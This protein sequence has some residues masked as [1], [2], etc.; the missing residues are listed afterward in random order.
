MLPSQPFAVYEPGTRKGNGSATLAE[1]IHRL[2]VQALGVLVI[3]QQCARPRRHP[4]R[5]VRA[6]RA[7][8]ARAGAANEPRHGIL[9]AVRCAAADGRLDELDQ[10][11]VAKSQL[12]RIV[13]RLFGCGQ[14][15]LVL[16]EP[17][18][19]DSIGVFREAQAHPFAAVKRFVCDGFAKLARVALV[20]APSRERKSTVARE[21]V[22][23]GLGYRLQLVDE[24]GRRLELA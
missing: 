3:C 13:A 16:P 14:R 20:H 8:A 24:H 1:P 15:L 9:C 11:P 12:G 23:S 21:A 22:L 6:A 7:G 17:V 5:P 18:V 4:E 2:E 19:E 10:A